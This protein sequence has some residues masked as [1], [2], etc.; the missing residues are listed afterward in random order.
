MTAPPP[1]RGPTPEAA[2][3]RV[4]SLGYRILVAALR[5]VPGFLLLIALPVAA[6]TFV[7]SHGYAIP[8]SVVA[9]T[10]WGA[11]LLAVGAAQYILKPTRAYGPL[12]IAYSLVGLL[13]LLYALSLSPYRFSLSGGTASIAAEYS[14]F[15]ELLLIVPALGIVAGLLTT[16]EDARSPGGRLPFDFP[17]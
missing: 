12:S 13:Y 5:L 10:A 9:V 3:A 7:N 8:I 4:P 16:I 17:G 6:L 15:L 14:K 1:A 11:A 2:P